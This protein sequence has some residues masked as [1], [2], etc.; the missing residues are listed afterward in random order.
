LHKI[1]ISNVSDNSCSEIKT[2]FC[3]ITSFSNILQFII[4][5]TFQ[6]CADHIRQYN[7]AHVH[8]I[9][10]TQGCKEIFTTSK[11]F[12]FRTATMIER[13]RVNITFY[14][15]CLSCCLVKRYVAHTQHRPNVTVTHP[16][17]CAANINKDKMSFIYPT[18]AQL[19][20]SKKC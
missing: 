16:M 13:T 2:H 5:K 12:C 11:T 15:L 3:T 7:L 10:G 14:L 19:Y 4:C 18:E 17:K 8:C 20:W 9:L 6:S 1:R